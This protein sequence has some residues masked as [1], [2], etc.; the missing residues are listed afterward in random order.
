MGGM[1]GNIEAAAPAATSGWHEIRGKTNGKN[2]SSSDYRNGIT[3][4]W[5]EKI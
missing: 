1:T 4:Y 3:K 5:F 2:P